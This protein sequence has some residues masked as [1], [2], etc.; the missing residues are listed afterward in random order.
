VDKMDEDSE[1]FYRFMTCFEYEKDTTKDSN[2]QYLLVHARPYDII[3]FKIPSKEINFD[4]F[5]THYD[6][7]I[8][9]YY[10]QFVYKNGE[11]GQ[12][13]EAEIQQS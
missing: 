13:E 8:K 6:K 10:I 12:E 5:W 9:Q 1:P 2:F 4:K 3:S 7:D 11:D